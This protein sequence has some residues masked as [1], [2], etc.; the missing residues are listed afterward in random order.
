MDIIVHHFLIF[1]SVR[2]RFLDFSK[3]F[4]DKGKKKSGLKT[5]GP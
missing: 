3:L 4:Q 1:V 2:M 5:D